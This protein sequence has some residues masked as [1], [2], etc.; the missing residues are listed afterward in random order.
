[1]LASREEGDGLKL[2]F[3]STDDLWGASNMGIYMGRVVGSHAWMGYEACGYDWD[4]D[5]LLFWFGLTALPIWTFWF[6][7]LLSRGFFCS[8]R[9]L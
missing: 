5:L 8:W 3:C 4:G 1:M 2:F 7:W 6:A 9:Y